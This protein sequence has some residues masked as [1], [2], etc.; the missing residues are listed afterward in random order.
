MRIL[1]S[2][3]RTVLHWCAIWGL[4]LHVEIAK[5]I[6]DCIRLV[7]YPDCNG[8]TTLHLAAHFG[9]LAL[10][11]MLIKSG[12]DKRESAA[13]ASC[14]VVVASPLSLTLLISVCGCNR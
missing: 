5:M 2:Q 3:Q 13:A 12:A 4:D 9:N 6:D 1:D 8:Q 11:E 10:V 7:N 14:C